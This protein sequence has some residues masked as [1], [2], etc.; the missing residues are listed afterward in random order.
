MDT[1]HT[2]KFEEIIS[3]S[4][5]KVWDVLWEDK[6]YR[7]WTAVF[8]VGSYAESDWKQ[9]SEIRF[10]GPEGSGMLSVIETR[11]ENRLMVFKHLKDI[12]KGELKETSWSGAT[13]SY[14][15]VAK[16]EETL[17]IVE[18]QSTEG[19]LKYFQ[20]TFPKALDLVRK[21]SLQD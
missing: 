11:V 10:L 9:G 12:V 7:Q 14:E 20:D 21:L 8:A 2:L 17:L 16:G 4:P 6:T 1:L 3:A 15:L 5:E 18:L 13:E 19:P